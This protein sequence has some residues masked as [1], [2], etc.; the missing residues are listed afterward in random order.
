MPARPLKI[1]ISSR[2]NDAFPQGGAPLSD[3]RRKIKE[4]LEEERLL[5]QPIFEVWINED[6]P[7]ADTSADSVAVC[8]EAVDDADV[9]IVLSNGNAGWA[10][11]A[12]EV[13]ICHAELMRGV[14]TAPAKVRLVSLGDAPIPSDPPSSQDLRNARFKTYLDTQAF[15]RGGSVK[16]PDAA[17][18]RVREAVFD[19]S[20][21][22]ARL[23][24]RESRKGKYYLGEALEWSSLSF[25]D[26]QRRI[27]DTLCEA[28]AGRNNGVRDGDRV[29]MKV[30]GTPILFAMHAIPASLGVA[31]AREMIGR[32]F[33]RDHQLVLALRN[34]AGPVHVIG[35]QKGATESQAAAFLGFPDA[36][37]VSGPFGIY[38]ADA[39]Q[40]VQFVFLRD[41]RDPRATRFSA[42]RFFDWLAQS[43]EDAAMVSR[44]SARARIVDAIERERE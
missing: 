44:A 39:I 23:G 43:G 17:L 4:S 18:A 42:Q 41:C 29:T 13:G 34:A 19:A 33:L 37:I 36:T 2:C 11:T 5:G 15:F 20:L 3:L 10:P 6:A 1:M 7:P 24:L 9:V 30:A 26:R 16:T 40:K 22:L 25:A 14:T 28:F 32:P 12:A 27:V 8:L 31:A 38:V 21:G 35:C